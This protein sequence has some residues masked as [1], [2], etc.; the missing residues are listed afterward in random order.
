MPFPRGTFH[1]EANLLEGGVISRATGHSTT[2]LDPKTLASFRLVSPHTLIATQEVDAGID[3]SKLTLRPNCIEI[4][5]PADYDAITLTLKK[6][7]PLHVGLA[8]V[9]EEYLICAK[10][11]RVTLFISVRPGMT[12][13]SR[14]EEGAVE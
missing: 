10:R 13:V 1:W 5:N 14:S 11:E 7:F 2:K 8:G 3:V 6:Q 9:R 4:L 12:R